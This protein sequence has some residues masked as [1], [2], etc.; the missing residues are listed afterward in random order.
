MS[1]KAAH[2]K[3]PAINNLDCECHEYTMW[4]ILTFQNKMSI[5]VSC[6]LELQFTQEKPDICTAGKGLKDINCIHC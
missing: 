4:V 1:F 6:Q 3:T 5:K 2:E